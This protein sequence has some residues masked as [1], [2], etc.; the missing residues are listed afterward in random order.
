MQPS[1]VCAHIGNHW[2]RM[3]TLSLLSRPHRLF[4]FLIKVCLYPGLLLF[5]LHICISLCCAS[6]LAYR[7]LFQRWMK[8]YMVYV[9]FTLKCGN[10]V[11]SEYCVSL[12]VVFCFIFQDCE[13]ETPIHKA[14]RS[15]S[16]DCISALVANGAH[17]E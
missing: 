6:N 16:L 2:S 7:I 14:A 8:W 1:R 15:G 12:F 17:I 10:L 9:N 3:Y 4:L 13:G 11:G 5:S